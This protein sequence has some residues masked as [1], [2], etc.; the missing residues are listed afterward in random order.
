MNNYMKRREFLA[1]SA[2][3]LALGL[4][5]G[6]AISA[7]PVSLTS[8]K[9][10]VITDEV[11]QDLEKALVWAKGFGLEWVELRFVWGK[12]VTDFTK[13]DV[14]K[15]RDLLSEFAMRVSVVDSAYFKTNLPG[16]QS[17]FADP[18][19]DPLQSGFAAQ[20]ALLERA[21]ARAKDFKAEK[22]RIFSFLRVPEPKKVFDRVAKE[23]ARSAELA[24]REQI[25]L[26]LE[27][28]FS[29]NVATGA[30]S[31][32]MLAAVKSSSLGL[33]W[34]PGN[35]Y[36]AGELKPY[37]DG[38]A[39]LDKSRL[40][41]MHLKDAQES[42][43]GGES[44]WRPIGGGKIDY[45]GQF[46]AL[47]KDGYSGTMSLETHYLNSAGDKSASSTESLQG[48]QSLLAKL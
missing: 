26:V 9:L 7:H 36:A 48:M 19:D 3:A 20:D 10:G 24:D 43:T 30:E 11:S 31:A 21:I 2:A 35:A 29:C 17:K 15:A 16:T 38:Y 47:I 6:K 1:G 44:V 45:P 34:D 25:K 39:P 8:F 40:W 13:E 4:A 27:N 14:G 37:P 12:Y 32:A 42:S 41:H 22:V 5:D 23:L 46:R 33:N 28:E 18:K